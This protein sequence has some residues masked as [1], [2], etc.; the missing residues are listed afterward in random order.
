MD[1]YTGKIYFLKHIKY[2]HVIAHIENSL[3][4]DYVFVG[5]SEEISVDFITDTREVEIELLEAEIKKKSIEHQVFLDTMSGKIQSLRAI[6]AP[7]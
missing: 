5:E 2:G 1:N 3:T 6:E 4:D 7:Q